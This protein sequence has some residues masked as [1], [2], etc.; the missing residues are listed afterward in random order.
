MIGEVV[1]QFLRWTGGWWTFERGA[2]RLCFSEKFGD[3]S[4]DSMKVD[5]VSFRF[6]ELVFKGSVTF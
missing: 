6:E 1:D 2:L 5:Y 4:I 3:L